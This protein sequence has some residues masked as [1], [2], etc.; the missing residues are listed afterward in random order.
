MNDEGL[1]VRKMK[2]REEVAARS[3]L[4]EDFEFP[5]VFKQSWDPPCQ[6]CAIFPPEQSGT[7]A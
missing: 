3:E 2:D 4:R 1:D 5:W 6:P 7:K